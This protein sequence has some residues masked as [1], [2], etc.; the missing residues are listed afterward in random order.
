[1]VT[2]P[3]VGFGEYDVPFIG[4]KIVL[5][6]TVVNGAVLNSFVTLSM[7]SHLQMNQ[8]EQSSYLLFKKI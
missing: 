7:L 4:Q 5:F 6:L 3:T 1:M 2:M 8:A